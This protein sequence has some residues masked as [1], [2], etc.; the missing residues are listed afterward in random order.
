MTTANINWDELVS[1]TKSLSDPEVGPGGV[2][3]VE[4][5]LI[6]QSL[7]DLQTAEDWGGIVRLRELFD[8]LV[9][10]ET[11]GGMSIVQRIDEAAIEAAGHLGDRKLQAR[12]LFDSGHN[13]HRQGYH[14]Q[15][16]EAL[17]R[18]AELYKAE[19]D[20]VR[21]RESYYMTSLPWRASGN[22]DRAREILNDILKSTS[23][24]DP[25][26]GN[27]LQVLSW[28]ERDKGNFVEAEKLLRE[29]LTL[30][31]KQE[32]DESIHVVQTLAD[33]GEV[34]G[35]QKRYDEAMPFFEKSL[36]IV[37]KFGGQYD[38]QEARAKLKYAEMLTRYG[39]YEKA[40]RL[41]DEADDR[42]RGYGHYYDLLWRIE[43]ARAF[44][45]FQR[46]QWG[47]VIRKFRAVLRYRS[48]LGLPNSLFAR[49]IVRRFQVGTG[50]P[51]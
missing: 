31:R 44:A 19:G 47:S 8:F 48:E 5:R 43:L 41:L 28:M 34:I 45:Y 7:I 35:L 13:R 42:I 51:S 39:D 9:I 30:Y 21:A 32:G 40:L 23:A 14:K 10:G 33:L 50:L 37:A 17:E 20:D 18:S 3:D 1:L 22:I 2:T 16:I 11:T 12:Y 27:P 46:R 49:Q 36:E 4:W 25:W 26:R 38:R 29:S 15:S 6:E 24:H